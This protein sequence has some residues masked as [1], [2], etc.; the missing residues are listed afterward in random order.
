MKRACSIFAA[1]LFV[2][3]FTVTQ[4]VAVDADSTAETNSTV[5]DDVAVAEST[6][7][8]A[9][10]GNTT[11]AGSGEEE[12]G[13]AATDDQ[14]KPV[15]LD[16]FIEGSKTD[17][18]GRKAIMMARPVSFEAVM[19]RLPEKRE[20]SYIYTALELSGVTNMPTVNHRMFLESDQG[21]ILPVYI[22]VNGVKKVQAGLKEGQRAKFLAYHAYNY[23]KGPAL[24]VVDF[25]PLKTM[26]E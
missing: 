19:K 16:S 26:G 12:A 25:E 13:T 5:A 11:D 2:A 1:A 21:R 10:A 14:F 17:Q 20:V 24:L 23:N 7:G 6:P 18:P 8:N 9:T 22:D 3:V 4:A 15:E